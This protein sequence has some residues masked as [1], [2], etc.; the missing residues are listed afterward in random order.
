MRCKISG[1]NSL[2]IKESYTKFFT[3][4]D[5][6]KTRFYRVVVYFGVAVN[7][8]G[9]LLNTAWTIHY[10]EPYSDNWIIL[11]LFCVFFRVSGICILSTVPVDEFDFFE[12]ILKYKNLKTFL[13]VGV[14]IGYVLYGIFYIASTT[15]S[16]YGF[17][18]FGLLYI[19]LGIYFFLLYF[20]KSSA[21]L[22]KEATVSYQKI[23]F[24]TH[25]LFLFVFVQFWVTP[26]NYLI[27]TSFDTFKLIC[28]INYIAFN[29]LAVVHF[30]RDYCRYNTSNDDIT[31]ELKKG[32]RTTTVYSIVYYICI[33]TCVS[34]ILDGLECIINNKPYFHSLIYF[35]LACG[36]LFPILFVWHYGRRRCFSFFA[37]YFEYDVARLQKDGA[38]M[39]SLLIQSSN[40]RTVFKDCNDEIIW[41]YRRKQIET[42]VSNPNA[43]DRQK[44]MLATVCSTINE[45]PLAVRTTFGLVSTNNTILNHTHKNINPQTDTHSHIVDLAV[46]CVDMADD[47]DNTWSSRFEKNYLL[48]EKVIDSSVTP[49]SYPSEYIDTEVWV[50]N[51]IDPDKYD[52]HVYTSSQQTDKSNLIY[53]K[54]I[55]PPV[56]KN[57]TQLTAPPLVP[58]VSGLPV[59]MNDLLVEARNRLRSFDW[60]VGLDDL[61][62]DKANLEMSK[63]KTVNLEPLLHVVERQIQQ[64]NWPADVMDCN[65]FN[66][67]PRDKLDNNLVRSTSSTSRTGGS[68]VV[69][70]PSEPASISDTVAG[71]VSASILASELTSTRL[72]K[73]KSGGAL[74][75]P[76]VRQETP[77]LIPTFQLSTP[78]KF[79]DRINLYHSLS[80]L[81]WTETTLCAKNIDYFVSHSWSDE[82]RAKY[83]ALKDFSYQFKLKYKRPPTY[84]IDT[85]CIDQKSVDKDNIPLLVF[86]ITIGTCQ[87]MLICLSKTYLTR[88]WCVWELF[89]LVTFCNKELALERIEFLLLDEM[90]L[91]MDLVESLR[92]FDIEKTH[93]FDPNEEFKLRRI[94][95]DIGVNRLKDCLKMVADAIESDILKDIYRQHQSPM[96]LLNQWFKSLTSAAKVTP[97]LNQTSCHGSLSYQY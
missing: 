13:S 66:T 94:I 14:G 11:N 38:L 82:A 89:T 73:S 27:A 74:A 49:F 67:S 20:L 96:M 62:T 33:M 52:Y 37:R 81:K 39:T 29:I 50:Q 59:N 75:I 43:V 77:K 19:F 32:W 86:P 25:V 72:K 63:K 22:N 26:L 36:D 45:I 70:G 42:N 85:V 91:S 35:L 95:F 17:Y 88:I 23:A 8:S 51:N 34:F 93:C 55:G 44:W 7:L 15:Y 46:F 54:A 92:E 41:I 5:K 64:Y 31:T 68:Y 28:A 48:R 18:I 78:M 16:S 76:I 53:L 6:E 90:R 58:T 57:L 83:T 9:A 69:P 24:R 60:P 80:L 40:F 87:R 47:M 4:R 2:T 10:W 71:A 65:V 56:E 79:F 21:E 1:Q 12:E 97:T 30:Y 3:A 84:W 61:F